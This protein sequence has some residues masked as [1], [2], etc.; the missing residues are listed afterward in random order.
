MSHDQLAAQLS[1]FAYC[2][3][4]PHRRH[5]VASCPERSPDKASLPPRVHPRQMD[6]TLAQ[7]ELHHLRH[8]TLRWS[9]HKHVHVIGHQVPFENLTLL[10]L[11]QSVEHLSKVLLQLSVHVFLRRFSMN[12]SGICALTSSGLG[13]Q[14]RPSRISCPVLGGSRSGVPRWTPEAVKLLLS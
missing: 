1:A 2:F 3:I 13:S 12:T 9:R 4:A 5:K 14:P 11:G 6:R 8:S 7:G 10:L